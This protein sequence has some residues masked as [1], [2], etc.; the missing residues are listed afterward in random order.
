MIAQC[1]NP[2]PPFD[3]MQAAGGSGAVDVDRARSL[4]PAKEE[5]MS[6]KITPSLWFTY[7]LQEALDFYTSVFEDSEI[8]STTA[9]PEGSPEP[10]GTLL[11]ASFRL[12][13]QHFVGINAGPHD[14]PNDA[15]SFVIEC[16]TQEEIDY[17]WERLTDGGQESQCGW[18]KDR[19]GFSWQVEPKLLITYL[20]DPDP[21]K[22]ARVSQAMF[23]MVKLDIAGLTRAYEGDLATL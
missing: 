22:A 20:Q 10:A 13:N 19:Y 1:R 17:Y 16:D 11:T 2:P 3:H 15:V 4:H 7:N 23:K 6:Q 9:Y 18:L 12:N 5:R 8:Y 21:E 14:T